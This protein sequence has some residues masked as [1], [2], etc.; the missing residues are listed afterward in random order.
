MLVGAET[1]GLLG[2]VFLLD[3]GE[4]TGVLLFEAAEGCSFGIL[5]WFGVGCL[6]P[7]GALVFGHFC[8]HIS[9]QE[10]QC[11]SRVALN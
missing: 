10:E 8:P 5:H 2:P 6:W 9:F 4:K 3:A 7:L 11:A 1:A